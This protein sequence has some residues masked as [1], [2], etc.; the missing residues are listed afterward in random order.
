MVQSAWFW[1]D[2][3]DNEVQGYSETYD[4]CQDINECVDRRDL[5]GKVIHLRITVALRYPSLNLL[6]RQDFSV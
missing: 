1:Y 5:R 4:M 3:V 6:I 2:A